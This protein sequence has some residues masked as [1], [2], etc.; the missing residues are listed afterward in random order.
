MVS[1][2]ETEKLLFS[3]DAFGRFGALSRTAAAPWA[4][5]ARHYYYNIVGKYGAQVQAL[6]EK[7]AALEFKAICPLHGPVLTGETL[8]EALRLYDLWS[9]WQSE[10]PEEILLAH[11]SIH[12]NT[13][14]AA[15][16]LKKKLEAEGA[17]V[18]LCDLTTTEVSY[19]VASAFYCGKLVLACSTYDSGLFPPMEAF[20]N[21][22]RAKGFRSRT[23]GLMENGSWAPAAA[24]LMRAKLE[25]M[26]DLHICNAVVSLRSALSPVNEVQMDALTTELCAE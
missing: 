5:Q 15:E 25:E 3:A 21:H 6:L 4:P 16:C 11:A 8:T 12:G 1:Y 20:L 26:K 14:R 19:A 2:E 9:H 24:R 7:A 13:A 23:V 17:K 10:A 22:L 18:T